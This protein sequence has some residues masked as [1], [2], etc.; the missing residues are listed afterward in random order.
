MEINSQTDFVNNSFY[1]LMFCAESFKEESLRKSIMSRRQCNEMIVVLDHD[2][3]LLGYTGPR[4]IW[5]NEMN[6]VTH[7]A[8]GAGS[9]A[10]PVV[11]RSTTVL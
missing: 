7:H 2:S 9:I 8:T 11:Q 6:F 4:T 3:A 1:G 5:A 10:Q